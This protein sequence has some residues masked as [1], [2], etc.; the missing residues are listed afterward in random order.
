MSGMTLS[1]MS[2]IRNPH[3]PPSTSLLDPS[4]HNTTL[5]PLY[6]SLPPDQ[7]RVA[8]STLPQGNYWLKLLADINWL[9][10]PNWYQVGVVDL[11]FCF[12]CLLD[13][14]RSCLS[15]NM[16]NILTKVHT[17]TYSNLHKICTIKNRTF[18]FYLNSKYL[19]P[20]LEWLSCHLLSCC[21]F[22]SELLISSS[23]F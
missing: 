20:P 15:Q 12:G 21:L 13:M 22:F 16:R 9:K 8:H 1:S 6:P 23:H 3:G 5:P 14:H 4:S 18:L 11:W 7:I 19:S 2:L 10:L 17:P